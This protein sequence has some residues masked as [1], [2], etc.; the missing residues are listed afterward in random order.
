[1]KRYMFCDT[2]YHGL[3]TPHI[4]AVWRF[5]RDLSL[6][7]LNFVLE[8]I[9]TILRQ[10]IFDGFQPPPPSSASLNRNTE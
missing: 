10:H 4:W 1:M 7:P 5:F 6:F 2:F 3:C 9:Y 8:I